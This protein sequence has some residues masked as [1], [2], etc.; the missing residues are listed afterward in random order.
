MAADV[1][2]DE[3][4]MREAI[5][6]ARCA[7]AMDEVPV[8]A[9]AVADGQVIARAHNIRERDGN[10]LGHAELLL[11]QQLM[12][13]VRRR[14]LNVGRNSND[15]S[16]LTPH[17]LRPTLPCKDWRLTDVTICVTC[18]PCLMCAGAMLQARI[19]RLVYGCKDPKAGAC[20]S[21]YD[22]TNDPRLNHRIDV[23]SGILADE[24]GKLLSDF[25][26]QLRRRG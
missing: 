3:L 26:G 20:G 8:G 7:A 5:A 13:N 17:V 16:R 19:P 4:F 18:E 10:P 14:T 15:A 1:R 2:N 23:T 25:F 22:V 12:N 9:A 24:C 6:E 11:L 21:L